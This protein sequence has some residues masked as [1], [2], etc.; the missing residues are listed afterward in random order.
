MGN[1]KVYLNLLT[2]NF[3]FSKAQAEV[4]NDVATLPEFSPLAWV[5]KS[6]MLHFQ[7]LG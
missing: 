6:K 4:N 3:S 1:K 7:E 2:S 5:L